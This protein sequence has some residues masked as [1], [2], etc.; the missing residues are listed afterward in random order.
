M[1]DA[2][3]ILIAVLAALSVAACQAEIEPTDVDVTPTET[4]GTETPE[5]ENTPEDEDT[6]EDEETSGDDDDNSGPGS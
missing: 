1:R 4:E 3:R 2:K 5:G 6:P